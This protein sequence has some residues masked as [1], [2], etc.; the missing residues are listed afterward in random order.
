[1]GTVSGGGGGEGEGAGGGLVL[2]WFEGGGMQVCA[3]RW[4]EGA[5]DI[6]LHSELFIM[7]AFS[8]PSSSV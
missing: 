2:A 3:T 1:M 5:L 4:T 7:A 8:C 6:L